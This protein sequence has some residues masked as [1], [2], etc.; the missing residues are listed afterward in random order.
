MS[1]GV[2]FTYRP[3]ATRWQDASARIWVK[4][5][6][7]NRDWRNLVNMKTIVVVDYD[8]TWPQVFEQLRSNVL[9]AVGDLA[10]S[11]EHVGSTAVPGLAGKPVIDMCVVVASPDDVPLAIERL[12][13]AGYEHRGNLGIDGRE[14][15]KQ[16]DA[17]PKHHMYV[18]ATKNLAL[19]N[20][21]A[22]RDYLRTHSEKA[23]EYG[24]LKKRLASHFRHDIDSYIDGKTDLILGILR[25]VGF[26]KDQIIA[27]GAVDLKAPT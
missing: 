18:C 13:T 9:H 8:Q 24:A 17:L 2:G 26:S 14:A 21:L 22:V 12:A 25:E 3:E 23:I 20:F 7:Y 11:I 16:P 27:I 19:L 6:V 4:Q 10:V 5:G 15:F 1:L